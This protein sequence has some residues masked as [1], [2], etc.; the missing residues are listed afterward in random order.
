MWTHNFQIR[1]IR[2]SIFLSKTTG[3]ISVFGFRLSWER[4]S[5]CWCSFQLWVCSPHINGGLEFPLCCLCAIEWATQALRN[6][7][8][9]FLSERGRLTGA[10]A[11]VRVFEFP[12][13]TK[14]VRFNDEKDHLLSEQEESI[15]SLS[16]ELS[17]PF[18]A[19]VD[20]CVQQIRP[21]H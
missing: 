18:G 21:V 4:F 15:H 20:R 7:S 19:C 6:F 8:S 13:F 17:F 1:A 11:R 12:F 3:S 16:S 9:S 10:W 14:V 5:P 2:M